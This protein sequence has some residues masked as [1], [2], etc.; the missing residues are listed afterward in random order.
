L[1]LLF[2]CKLR[3]LRDEF[4]ISNELL[5]VGCFWLAF[6][7]IFL[8]NGNLVKFIDQFYLILLDIVRNYITV[9]ISGLF[10]IIKSFKS[11]NLPICTT[12]ECAANFNL[13]LYTEKTYDAFF[14]YLKA[15]M[16][17]GAKFLSF[18][19][20]LNVFKYTQN[21]KEINTLSTDI[22][23]KYLNENSLLYIEFPSH[24]VDS[25]HKSYQNSGKS[26]Y[27]NVF[28]SLGEFA[29]N[30]LKDYYYPNF[31]MSN[32]YKQ[33]ENELERDEVIYSRLVASSMIQSADIEI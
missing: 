29:Y 4:N 12:K 18:H 27:S 20:E 21:Q 8:V 24:L 19:T 13:L 17:E 6:E 31:K 33:L 30:A 14:N 23:E 16:P 28:D 3:N 7:I 10:P 11:L 22:Y 32:E 5:T 2:V 25:L 9:I 26:C 15:Y 1:V